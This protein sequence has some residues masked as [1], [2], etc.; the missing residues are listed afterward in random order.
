MP[1]VLYGEVN[2]TGRYHLAAAFLN[3]KDRKAAMAKVC[4]QSPCNHL[5]HTQH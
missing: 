5:I 3:I 4:F 1:L 2:E